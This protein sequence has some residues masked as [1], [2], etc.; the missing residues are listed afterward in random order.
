MTDEGARKIGR[1]QDGRVVIPAGGPSDGEQE[2]GRVVIPPKPEP[3]PEPKG[4]TNP[5]ET[6][7]ES[8]P[9]WE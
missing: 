2:R 6:G 3:K 9:K 1:I 8:Q 7:T 4:T 5:P